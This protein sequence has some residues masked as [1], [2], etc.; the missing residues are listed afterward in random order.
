MEREGSGEAVL[1]YTCEEEISL[2]QIPFITTDVI[3]GVKSLLLAIMEVAETIVDG[4]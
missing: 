3:Q 1:P 4:S 2:I